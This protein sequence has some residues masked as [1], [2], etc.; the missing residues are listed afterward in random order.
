MIWDRTPVAPLSLNGSQPD[1]VRR[2]G[3]LNRAA[4]KW[5]SL[6]SNPKASAYQKNLLDK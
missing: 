3:L 5:C 6:G 4:L 1:T 2:A